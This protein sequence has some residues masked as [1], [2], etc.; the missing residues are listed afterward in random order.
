MS[1]PAQ[2]KPSP[3]KVDLKSGVSV[4][5]YNA[6]VTAAKIRTNQRIR[7]QFEVDVDVPRD[8]YSSIIRALVR[9]YGNLS[10]LEAARLVGRSRS[11][12]SRNFTIDFGVPFRS[13]CCQVR[14]YVA[15]VL[16]TSTSLRISEIA[17][18]LGYD[19]LGTF[20][21]G[22][23]RWFGASPTKYRQDF[24]V[25]QVLVFR[26]SG[27]HSGTKRSDTVRISHTNLS[28]Q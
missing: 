6:S 24:E 12:F 25:P 11:D 18:S 21:R 26:T 28:A 20:G 23:R 8:H 4:C 15:A 27:H 22:F 5:D 19:S 9:S 3:S 1:S 13:A 10:L 7:I 2:E 17:S 14:F 16:L